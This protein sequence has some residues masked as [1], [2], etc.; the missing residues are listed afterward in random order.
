MALANGLWVGNIP[1][2]L[3]DLTFVERLL[4]S[5]IRSNRCIVH[6]LKGGWKMRANAI[7]FPAPVPK[8]CNILPPPIEELDEVIAFMFTGVAQP[9]AED[10]KRT[11]MLARRRYISA[12]LE[13]L[14]TNHLDYADVQISQENLKHYPEEGPPVTVDYR[15]SI[16]NKHKEATSVFDMEDED[17]VH[18]GKCPFVVHGITGENYSTLSKDAT[19]ALALQHLIKDQ[20]ILFVGHGTKPESMFNNSQLFPSMM[21]WL[22]PYGLGGIGNSKIA[23]PVSSI[24]QKKHLLMYHDKRFQTDPGFPLIAFNQEQIQQSSSAGFVTAKKPYFAEVTKRLMNLDKKV[25][26]DITNRMMKGERVKPETDAE[27]ACFRIL[28]DIDTVGGRVKGSLTSKKYMRNNV[29][30]LISYIGAPS[31]FITLS[32]ADI[33]HPICIYF[34]DKN[35][36]F[37]P[38][39]YFKKADDAYRLVTS[40]PVAAA[41]FFHMMCQNFIKHVLGFGKKH[42]GL[43][44]ETKAFY[45]TVEQQGRLTL[46]L[47]MLIWIKGALS[48]Q[49]VRDKILDTESDF[50]RSM[51][52]YLESV[53]QGEFFEGKLE[54]VIERVE[55]YQ[56]NPEYVPPTKTMPE[57]PPPLCAENN[58]CNICDNC[59]ALTNWWDKFKIVVDDL[60][61]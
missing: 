25:L 51:V 7:M 33:N 21:P 27:I 2:E 49:E 34:A 6:V 29:W 47:H 31:W 22:F 37:K 4:V 11:P 45:G 52:E 1:K 32:P 54:D 56:N 24:A 26:E 9:T 17:G 59:K 48:P 46:H 50:Q 60:V 10:M 20:N 13:W 53:H 15:S 8:L 58:E 40:N 28:S 38:D 3:S 44:G 43:Y 16:V 19:R 41:R 55:G 57:A 36:I 23:G 61:K 42:P 30:S 5:R 39:L 14:K 18:E 35:I 12:A